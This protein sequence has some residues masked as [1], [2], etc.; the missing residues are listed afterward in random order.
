[1]PTISILGCNL[2]FL[3]WMS[4][5]FLVLFLLQYVLELVCLYQL[6]L[7]LVH[8]MDSFILKVCFCIIQLNFL[9]GR[10]RLLFYCILLFFQDH[11]LW[12]CWISFVC[13]PHLSYF[14][15][16]NLYFP[17]HFGWFPEA[18]SPFPEQWF[19]TMCEIILLLLMW[20]YFFN[21]LVA[22]SP[23]FYFRVVFPLKS[24]HGEVVFQRCYIYVRAN[25]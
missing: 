10:G 15:I 4:T 6:F 1:M 5:W 21:D 3:W 24:M 22:S 2:L 14:L 11:Q 23:I 19:P 18:V 25:V 17:V 20:L 12:A 9:E 16:L 8:P 13:L 7:N